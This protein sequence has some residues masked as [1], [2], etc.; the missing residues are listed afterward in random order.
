MLTGGSSVFLLSVTGQVEE[1]EF[2]DHD[3]LYCRLFWVYGQDWLLTAGQEE[4][5]SQVSRCSAGDGRLVWNFPIDISLKATSPHGWPRLVVAVY[6]PDLLG[7]D[8]VRGYG[9]V[10]A[11]LAP[12]RHRKRV[13]MFVPSSSSRLQSLAGWILGRR[14]ELVDPRSVARGEGRQVTRVSTQGSVTVT[15]NVI[16][17]DLAR[18]GYETANLR[19]SDKEVGGGEEEA[20]EETGIAALSI[21]ES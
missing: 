20:L 14:P 5:L 1:G 21:K 16:T 6:G 11:P 10:L 2:P 12:G 15:L 18:L 13:P 8:V 4:G 17:K 19:G 9:A 7:N 3:H